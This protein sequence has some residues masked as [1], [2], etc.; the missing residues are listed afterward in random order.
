MSPVSRALILAAVIAAASSVFLSVNRTGDS[1]F[2]RL[3]ED[4]PKTRA[5]ESK[6]KKTDERLALNP[7]DL[8]ALV[9]RGVAYF[10]MGRDHHA[11]ALN[12]FNAAWQAGALDRRIFY[13][14]GVVYEDLTLY[15]EAQRQYER[16]LR[17]EPQDRQIKMRLARLLFKMGK[18]EDSLARYQDYIQENEKDAT[19]ILNCG[20]AYYKKIEMDLQA[21][22]KPTPQDNEAVRTDAGKALEYLEKAAR[23]APQ[24]PEGIHLSMAK[25]YNLRQDWERAALSAEAE[26]AVSTAAA[27]PLKILANASEQLN[28]PDKALDAYSKLSQ[29]EPRNPAWNRKT[30]SLKKLLAKK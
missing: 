15:E 9:D 1:F 14:S 21:N 11:D 7:N 22:K 6:L 26:L 8:Q 13:Y 10:F 5:L 3:G 17:H 30:R 2:P 29:L 23:I 24:L 27:A 18:W 12:A 16:F 25:L 4:P 28:R 19:S 20:L